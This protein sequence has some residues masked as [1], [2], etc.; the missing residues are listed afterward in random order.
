MEQDTMA[1]M[2]LAASAAASVGAL[3]AALATWKGATAWKA[4]ARCESQRLALER[5]FTA[6]VKFRGRLKFVYKDRVAWAVPADRPDIERV[7]ES[8][9][10]WNATW[11]AV[12]AN[13][14]GDL[15]ALA[16]QLWTDVYLAYAAFM[17][18]DGTLT[19]LG[20]A[21]E[22]AYN[23]TLLKQAVARR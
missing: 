3:G 18:G 13:L 5:W 16:T 7:S 8:F 4:Q 10:E 11:P 6:G 1:L 19:A 14:E 12:A 15:L 17:E 9:W 22:A 20:N 2:T 21:V 23:S